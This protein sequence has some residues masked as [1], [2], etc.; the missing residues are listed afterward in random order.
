MARA[1]VD[2]RSGDGVVWMRPAAGWVR[3]GD[4]AGIDGNVM[5]GDANNG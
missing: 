5:V 3:V 2:G 1:G 4:V